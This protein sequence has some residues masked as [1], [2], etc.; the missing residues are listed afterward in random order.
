MVSLPI[1][2]QTERS[3][4]YCA[5]LLMTAYRE[6][7]RV[8]ESLHS[9]NILE[10]R[11]SVVFI[12]SHKF[13]PPIVLAV[14]FSVCLSGIPL[15][16]KWIGHSPLTFSAT[17]F[18]KESRKAKLRQRHRATVLMSGTE[19]DGAS[20]PLI[21]IINH[22]SHKPDVSFP[23]PPIISSLWCLL[24]SPLSASFPKPP[25]PSSLCCCKRDLLHN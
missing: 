7:R 21:K 24:P 19:S 13:C 23:N 25:H 5:V 8:M 4:L 17:E 1:S 14:S 16:S 10:S 12:Y 11:V 3:T 9:L 15:S 18:E 20:Q 22:S 6:G 2:S